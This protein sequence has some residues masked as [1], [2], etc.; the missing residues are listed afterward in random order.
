MRSFLAELQARGLL[1]VATAYLAVSWLMLEIGHT[2]FNIFELP[3]AGL[4]FVFVLLTLGFPLV[5]LGAWQGWLG[6]AVR[7]PDTGADPHTGAP[8]S[9]ATREGPWFAIVFAAVALFAV[10]VAIGV[11]FFGMGRNGPGHGEPPLEATSALETA[12]QPRASSANVIAPFAPPA[13]SVAVLSFVNMSGD[14]KDEYFSDGLSEEL[15]NTLVRINELQVAARTSSFSFKGTAAD[16]PTVGRKLNVA[17]V[18]EGSVRK[19]GERVRITAQLIN[20]V[21]GFHLWSETYDRDLKDIFALQTEIASAV[22]TAMKVTLLGETKQHLNDS[23]TSN[24]KAFD[25]YLRA[26]TAAH[27]LDD[28]AGYRQA[29]AAYD[30]AIALDPAFALA[31]AGRAITLADL[32]NDW[33]GDVKQRQILFAQAR[34]SAA[35][36]IAQAPSSGQAYAALAHVLVV[37]SLDYAALEAAIRRGLSL[38]PGNAEILIS[39]ASYASGLGRSDTLAA[40]DHAVALNPLDPSAYRVRGRVLLYLQ[41]YDDARAS[42]QKALKLDNSRTSRNSAASVELATG[43][44]AAALPFCEQDRASWGSQWCL[45]IAYYR[46]GRKKEA[47]AM[48][49]L[50][51]AQQGDALAFQYAEVYAQWGEPAQVIKWLTTAMRLQDGGLL[52]IRNDPLLDPVRNTPAFATIVRQLNFPP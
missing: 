25:A 6:A 41:Q 52:D 22:A 43:H 26:R 9:A 17:A 31:Y 7:Q 10:A 32:V 36:A 12:S 29:L 46:L 16:I 15:L 14:A 3:H 40:A 24:P 19:A 42:M 38:E 18:L 48:L 49:E 4:Q 51:K 1:K 11:R 47:A 50:M 21:T 8:H 27:N 28:E 34:A 20:A 5:L 44:Y 30:E 2:L 45:A 23:G 37:T 33:V 35:K 13:H 39:Y